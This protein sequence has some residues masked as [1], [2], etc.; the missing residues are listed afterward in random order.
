MD[1]GFSCIDNACLFEC[2]KGR[3]CDTQA[4]AGCLTC[5]SARSCDT[6]SSCG[7][8]RIATSAGCTALGVNLHLVPLQGHCGWSVIDTNGDGGLFGE[9]Y[10][11]DDGEYVAHLPALG[12]TC[13]G[14]DTFGHVDRWIISCPLCQYEL[15][16]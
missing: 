15:T 1:A 3:T 12:G 6:G 14:V 8:P 4:D 9:I 7:T 10:R 5:G 11:L 16:L 13:T 2:T